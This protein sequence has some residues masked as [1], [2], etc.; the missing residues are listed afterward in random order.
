MTAVYERKT[1][2]QYNLGRNVKMENGK[3]SI[4]IKTIKEPE[5]FGTVISAS[6]WGHCCTH[7]GYG[8]TEW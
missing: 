3:L 6:C 7:G 8:N 4:S 5:G 2:P 1:L